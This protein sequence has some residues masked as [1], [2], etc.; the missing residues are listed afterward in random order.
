RAVM[1]AAKQYFHFYSSAGRADIDLLMQC[2]GAAALA[3][4]GKGVIVD[5]DQQ[6]AY[7]WGAYAIAH[8]N[9][10]FVFKIPA[11]RRVEEKR[12]SFWRRMFGRPSD[13]AVPKL[14]R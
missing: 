14:L 9:T 10:Q 1:R 12:T 4:V 5:E 2:Y 11:P 7:G 6:M 3:D 13:T 8:K